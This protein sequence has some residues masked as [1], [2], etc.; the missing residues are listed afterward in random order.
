LL[1]CAGINTLILSI[2][3]SEAIG[4]VLCAQSLEK[5]RSVCYYTSYKFDERGT[6]DMAKIVIVAALRPQARTI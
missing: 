2:S 5:H 1:G 6:Q 4:F 3:A